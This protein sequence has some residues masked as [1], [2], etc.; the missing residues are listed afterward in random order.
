MKGFKLFLK[1]ILI[2]RLLKVEAKGSTRSL[3]EIVEEESLYKIDAK[4]T[5]LLNEINSTFFNRPLN[6][7]NNREF[8]TKFQMVLTGLSLS[9]YDLADKIDIYTDFS[10]Y[11]QIRLELEREIFKKLQTAE[12][13]LKLKNLI[14]ICRIFFTN[15]Q[16]ELK[17]SFKESNF[18]KLEILNNPSPDCESVEFHKITMPATSLTTTTPSTTSRTTPKPINYDELLQNIL[19]KYNK[20]PWGNRKYPD[21]DKKIWVVLMALNSEERSHKKETYITF[22]AYDDDREKLDKELA[23]RIGK[24]KKRIENE[25]NADCKSDLLYLNKKLA[26][27]MYKTLDEKR[28]VLVSTNFVLSCAQN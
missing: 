24:F 4:Y 18:M 2:T 20:R 11:N 17:A 8:E 9:I 5:T 14:P 23:I 13:L 1:I 12:R 7:A 19:L 25:S 28:A 6:T 10:T 15:Q 27:N 16:D 3:S 21:F 22:Q 26:L